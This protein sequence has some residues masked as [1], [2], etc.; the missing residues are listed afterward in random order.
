MTLDEIA[1]RLA[2]LTAP[3]DGPRGCGED[4]TNCEIAELRGLAHIHVLE[5]ALR[6]LST[7]DLTGEAGCRRAQLIATD[8]LHHRLTPEESLAKHRVEK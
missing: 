2:V 6:W 8:A 7:H 5:D 3:D 1:A 4:H